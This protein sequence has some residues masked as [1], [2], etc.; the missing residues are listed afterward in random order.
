[1]FRLKYIL[2]I[3]FRRSTLTQ[4][5]WRVGGGERKNALIKWT[6]LVGIII[7]KY[8]GGNEITN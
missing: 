2:K 7:M 6:N 1:M 5:R 8:T 3:G 4:I